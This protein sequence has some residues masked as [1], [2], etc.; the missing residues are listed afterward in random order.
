MCELVKFLTK[1]L[2]T[3]YLQDSRA[4]TP[5]KLSLASRSKLLSCEGCKCVTSTLQS[6]G[7]EGAGVWFFSLE[8]WGH[9]PFFLSAGGTRHWFIG[10]EDRPGVEGRGVKLHQGDFI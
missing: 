9:R 5:F 2:A 3:L 8:A 10:H 4:P 6:E 1:E 7:R